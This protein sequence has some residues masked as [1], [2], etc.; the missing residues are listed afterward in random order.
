T[1]VYTTP[2]TY[3]VTLVAINGANRDTLVRNNY[4]FVPVS[5][6]PDFSVNTQSGC[7]TGNVFNFTNLTIN[8]NTYTWDFGDGNFS[9]A[10]NPS[11][12][13][14]SPG[15]Y[16]VKL[17]AN[18]SYGCTR[19]KTRTAYI[20]VNPD[21]TANYTVNNITACD[22]NTVF[23]FSS[24]ALGASSH[25]WIFS[26][27]STSTQ[28]NPAVTFGAY[29]TYGVTLVVT[30][31]AGC[32]DT[33][34]NSNQITIT[35]PV[36]PSVTVNSTNGCA[37]FAATFNST[38]PNAASWM[39]SF[40]DGTTSNLEDPSHTY[41]QTGT[42]NVSLTV[43]TTTGCTTSVSLPNYITVN[44]APVPSFTIGNTVSCAPV[45]TLFTNTSN[46][47]VSYNWTFG[48]GTSSNIAS[49]TANFT[50]SGNYDVT[51][52]ATSANGCTASITQQVNVTAHTITAFF[53]GNPTTGCAPLPVAFTGSSS[54]LATSWSWSF[55]DG[56]T[57]SLRNP[58]NTYNAIGNYNVTLVVTSAQGCKDTLIK[59]AYIKVVTDTAPYTVPDTMVV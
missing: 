10:L 1:T 31:A 30:S 14:A 49:P 45:Q 3:T 34:S 46:G 33:I 25:Q 20:T 35:P 16:T 59:N 2:G 13:Y 50:V 21:P 7:E 27:G 6:I 48:N 32:S 9:S 58:S 53:T 5:P 28:I 8:G 54:P 12:T 36:A 23:Q 44:P 38:T 19:V 57:S 56:N 15:T 29:G 17:I 51:L 39:W 47:A 42:Y 41:Q 26:N 55:G 18:N 24:A 43:V 40:G 37:P 11:H 22:S 52:T 4:I